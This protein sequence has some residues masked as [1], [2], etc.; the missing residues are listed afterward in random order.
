M[1]KLLDRAPFC[2]KNVLR[3]CFNVL[4]PSWF[5]T[6]SQFLIVSQPPILLTPTLCNTCPSRP[7]GALKS[8]TLRP[9]SSHLHS[10]ETA[11]LRNMS[12]EMN[13]SK[14]PPGSD[15]LT[16]TMGVQSTGALLFSP[17]SAHLNIPHFYPAFLI[18]FQA[19]TTPISK[20][21]SNPA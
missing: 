8:G 7:T 5:F 6:M 11:P 3:K 13:R 17:S 2:H 21:L 1:E 18:P 19:L 4:P 15:P 16:R 10:S 12:A 9:P 20:P 14:L